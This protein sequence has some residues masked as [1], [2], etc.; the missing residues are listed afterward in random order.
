MLP[1]IDPF[2]C[3]ALL[4]QGDVAPPASLTIEDLKRYAIAILGAALAAAA[5]G[6]WK[7]RGGM[8]VVVAGITTAKARLK[9]ALEAHPEASAALKAGGVDLN[10]LADHLGDNLE[11]G[12]Q[13]VAED[14]GLE[15]KVQAVVASVKGQLEKN[16]DETQ[17]L[18]R[19]ALNPPTVVPDEGAK[20]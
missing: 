15:P 1:F 14:A 7:N 4:A 9:L 20:P 2:A 11:R 19:V 16:P 6:W 18:K 3:F 17:R 13:A 10:D 5:R 12:I 8:R